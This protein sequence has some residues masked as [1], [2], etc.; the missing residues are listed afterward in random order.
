MS[1]YSYFCAQLYNIPAR[2]F[3]LG[4][5][6]LLSHEGITQGDTS[7]MAVYGIALAPL[8]KHVATCYS[9]RHP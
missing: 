8:L 9:E 3:V 7:A 5:K 6:E 2:L 1:N 4:G